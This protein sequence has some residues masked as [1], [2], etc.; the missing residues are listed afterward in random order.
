MYAPGKVFRSVCPCVNSFAAFC[1]SL[2]AVRAR[3]GG[4]YAQTFPDKPITILV[5]YAARRKHRRH[6][7]HHRPGDVE[8]A[9]PE[10]RHRQPAGRRRP[11]RADRG[12]QGQA[13]RLHDGAGG[14]DRLRAGAAPRRPR[15]P[16]RCEDF[17][18]LGSVTDT[19][20]VLEVP[21]DEPLQDLRRAGGLR[22]GEPRGGAHRPC[23]Q[24]HDQPSSRS[25]GLQ[26][27]LGAK[28]TAVPYKRLG[29]GHLRPAGQQ[30][31]R[32]RRP[33]PQLDGPAPLGRASSRWR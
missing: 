7:A 27:M 21:A 17:A 23:R 29:A 2:L 33:D 18:G 24:R 4:P 14:H 31:R 15:R 1:L 10:L 19:P 25:C 9:G 6:G 3:N 13:R 28:F 20:L 12:R 16:I 30:H 32:R 26:Q 11:D 8:G 22:E 5:G